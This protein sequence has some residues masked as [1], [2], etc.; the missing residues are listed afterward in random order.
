M[1]APLPHWL[2]EPIVSRLKSI[3]FSANPEAPDI[4]FDSPH[5]QPNHVLINEYPPG[6]GI[7]PHQVGS[8]YGDSII[9]LKAH[10]DILGWVGL[11]SGSLYCELGC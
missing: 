6:I 9:R 4:F 1:D 11:S 3:P 2:E 7:M 5:T 10:R 8:R